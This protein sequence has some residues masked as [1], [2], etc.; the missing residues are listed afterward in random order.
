MP[1]PLSI[2]LILPAILQEIGTIEDP[3]IPNIAKPIID[4]NTELK[5]IRI[6]KLKIVKENN[7]DK[8]LNT[9]I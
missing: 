5:L 4:E 8:K 2:P 1:T 7:I 9:P 3:P 6:N